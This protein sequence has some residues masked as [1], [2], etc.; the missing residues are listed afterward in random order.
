VKVGLYPHL[1]V[2]FNTEGFLVR[3]DLQRPAGIGVGLKVPLYG[4]L[5]SPLPLIA[6]RLD[7]WSPVPIPADGVARAQAEI[8]A[9]RTWGG[10]ALA[11]AAGGDFAAS[12]SSGPMGGLALGLPEVGPVGLWAE[13]RYRAGLFYGGGA[14][15]HA[16]GRDS[17]VDLGAGYRSDGAVIGRAGFTRSFPLP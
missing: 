6:A 5:E 12:G 16:L 1:Q 7:A 4:D 15:S 11:V 17:A 2:H 10:F 8:V 14:V 3:Q 9:S 13:A